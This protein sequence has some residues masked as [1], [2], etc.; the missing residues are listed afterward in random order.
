MT[1]PMIDRKF[2]NTLARGLSILQVFRPTEKGLTHAQIAERTGLPKATITRLTY[3]LCALGYLTTTHRKGLFSLGPACLS[4]GAIATFAAGI[5]DQVSQGMQ[6]IADENHA[7]TSIV[8]RDAGRMTLVRTWS[9]NQGGGI[10]IAPGHQIPILGSSTGQAVISA[11]KDAGFEALAPDAA[12]RAFRHNGQQQLRLRGFTIAPRHMR[13]AGRMNAVS[14][15]CL[16]PTLTEPVGFSCGGATGFLSDS[17]LRN[18]VG[19]ALCALVRDIE[20]RAP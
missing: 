20:K 6:R 14:V 2:A 13:Y 18:D 3:T 1:L 16:A 17:K 9:P 5:F 8:V 4:L 11:M 12:L 19:P 15:P 10:Q 7:M